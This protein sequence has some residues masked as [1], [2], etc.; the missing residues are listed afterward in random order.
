ME[1][2]KR[3]GVVEMGEERLGPKERI[4]GENRMN[5][6]GC[7]LARGAK[8]R[9]FSPRGFM[10]NLHAGPCDYCISLATTAGLLH[11]Y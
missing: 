3:D 5:Q 4:D 9:A 1:G 10:V 2:E 8:G 11:E 6:G 7:V